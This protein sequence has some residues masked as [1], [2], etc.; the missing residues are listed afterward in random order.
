[1]DFTNL[2]KMTLKDGKATHSPK[3][4]SKANTTALPELST[5]SVRGCDWQLQ[6]SK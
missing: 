6:Y 4:E 3:V 2:E 5:A 1:M